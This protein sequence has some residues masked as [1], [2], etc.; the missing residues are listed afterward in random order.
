[1]S[2]GQEDSP[3]L[4]WI[5]EPMDDLLFAHSIVVS[6]ITLAENCTE[7]TDQR[8]N[9]QH[10]PS[11]RWFYQV[12]PMTDILAEFLGNV[13]EAVFGIGNSDKKIYSE[14][15]N[16]D[17]F[18]GLLLV[19]L[20]PMSP[21]IS[22]CCKNDASNKCSIWKSL[23]TY[24]GIEHQVCHGILKWFWIVVVDLCWG[25]YKWCFLTVMSLKFPVD[26]P[27]EDIPLMFTSSQPLVPPA[28]LRVLWWNFSQLN[29]LW[30]QS[31]DL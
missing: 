28:S 18:F 12:P 3:N 15:R 2:G 1:M 27:N 21:S 9:C 25:V 14:I 31:P 16:L 8:G 6:E 30:K 22:I 20:D 13:A 7:E 11:C 24:K 29:I 17:G 10:G 26:K 5:H 23:L 19:S 4:S